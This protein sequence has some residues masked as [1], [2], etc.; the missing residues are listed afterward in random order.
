MGRF[1]KG[2]KTDFPSRFLGEGVPTF[3]FR[4]RRYSALLES[5]ESA[6]VLQ[7]SNRPADRSKVE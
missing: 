6:Q 2:W 1:S 4:R 7:N 5:A 3:F